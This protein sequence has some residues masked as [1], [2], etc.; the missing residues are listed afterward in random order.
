MAHVAYQ[1]PMWL[2]NGPCG[3]PMAH[4][5]HQWPMWL[6]NGPCGLPMAHVAHQWP[7]W[8]TNGPC[9]SPMAHVAHQWPMWLTNGPCGLPVVPPF[10]LFP[11]KQWNNSPMINCRVMRDGVAVAL[12][13]NIHLF[14]S[15]AENFITLVTVAPRFLAI[16]DDDGWALLLLFFLRRRASITYCLPE[17]KTNSPHEDVDLRTQPAPI[18]VPP[19]HGRARQ[20]RLR[21]PSGDGQECQRGPTTDL[22]HRTGRG[23]QGPLQG[24]VQSIAQ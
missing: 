12:T 4:V 24:P 17:K 19:L 5:A 18:P 7:M 21:A 6:T 13:W 11:Q 9:G 3:S 14:L 10:E 23:A 2:T 22:R 1:W 8:L 16:H 20:H 15:L